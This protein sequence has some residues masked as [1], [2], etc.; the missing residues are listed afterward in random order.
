MADGAVALSRGVHTNTPPN[1]KKTLSQMNPFWRPDEDILIEKMV[2]LYGYCWKRISSH[3][4]GRTNNAVRNRFWRIQKG[5]A[6]RS[7]TPSERAGYVCRSC[8]AAKRGHTCVARPD[9]GVV[10]ETFVDDVVVGA[11]LSSLVDLI[12]E[13]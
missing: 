13:F 1:N 12:H 11:Y 9:A 8:G 10:E 3:L 4:H 5:A 6:Q 2:E 7:A